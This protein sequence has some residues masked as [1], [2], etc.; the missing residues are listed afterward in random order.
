LATP[1]TTDPH[2][3]LIIFFRPHY[4]AKRKGDSSKAEAEA[5]TAD[6]ELDDGETLDDS[7]P[8]TDNPANAASRELESMPGWADVSSLSSLAECVKH[9][10]KTG[11]TRRD[12]PHL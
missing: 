11:M 7:V 6:G 9:W 5:S 1:K 12:T 10:L 2:F 3:R 8:D 4:K